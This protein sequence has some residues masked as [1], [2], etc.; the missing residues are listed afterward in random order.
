MGRYNIEIPEPVIKAEVFYPGDFDDD[1]IG[2]RVEVGGVE[3]MERVYTRNYSERNSDRF[4]YDAET[5][6]EKALAEFG[7]AIKTLFARNGLS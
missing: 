7:E 3:V 5:A 4:T 1:R 2:I 6:T